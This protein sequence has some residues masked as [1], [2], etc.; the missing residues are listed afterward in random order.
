[1]PISALYSWAE[2]AH[3][4]PQTATIAILNGE[5]RTQPARFHLKSPALAPPR[6]AASFDCAPRREASPPRVRGGDPGAHREGCHPSCFE[7]AGQMRLARLQR[8]VSDT[9]PLAVPSRKR[10]DSAPCGRA[11]CPRSQ[12][13][14]WVT[15][16]AK[17]QNVEAGSCGRSA[18][19]A[20]AS[21]RLASP[22]S[23]PAKS[24]SSGSPCRCFKD[25]RRCG[26]QAPR[27]PARSAE[28]FVLARVRGGDRRCRVAAFSRS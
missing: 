23:W 6:A 18:R 26:P 8:P 12:P 13:V 15:P 1:M 21:S 24:C 10:Q 16:G 11:L 4:G 9:T 17:K 5:V 3:T 20:T 25:R 2:A 22:S 28:P 19:A 14:T 27:C 7:N